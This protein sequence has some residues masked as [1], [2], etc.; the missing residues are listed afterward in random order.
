MKRILLA[1][2]AV[3]LTGCGVHNEE[4]DR[5]MELRTQLLAAQG[6]SFEAVVTADYSDKTYTFTVAYQADNEGNI[7]FEVREPETIEGITGTISSEGGKL[8]FDDK[9]V[10][11]ELLADGQVTPVSAGYILVKTLRSGYVR[12][13][14]T[15]GDGVKL[16]IDDS[17]QEEALHLDIRLGQGNTPV[18]AEILYKDRRFLSLEVKNFCLL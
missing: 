8:T 4:L 2:V 13:C 9:A 3:F 16:L 18:S 7:A 10:A 17:Y 15:D 12:G 11:F 5:A 14:G 1:L 6:C